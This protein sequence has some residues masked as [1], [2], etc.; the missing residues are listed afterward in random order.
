M[1][2]IFC[3]K[4]KNY[5]AYLSYKLDVNRAREYNIKCNS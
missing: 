4:N 2:I 5:L 1:T 3:F